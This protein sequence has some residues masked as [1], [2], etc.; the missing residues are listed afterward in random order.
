MN[1]EKKSIVLKISNQG[2]FYN[3]RGLVE[4]RDTNFPEKEDFSLSERA[5][6]FWEVSMLSFD[7]RTGELVIE[8]IDYEKKQAGDLLAKQKPKYSIRRIT[9]TKLKWPALE[10]ILNYYR[11]EAFD[12]IVAYPEQS[13]KRIPGPPL[14]AFDPK[15]IKEKVDIKEKH[16]L[17]KTKF[18]MGFVELDKKIKGLA[19]PIKI[20]LENPHIIPEFDH[21]KPF[22][23][24]A[25]GKRTI[26]ITG[27]VEINN[28][29]EKKVRCRSYEI[30]QINESLITNVK[31][32][33]L[34]DAVFKPKIHTIDK[35]LF[36][37][38][39]YFE[40]TPDNSLGNRPPQKARD[41][42][43]EILEL[44]GIRNRKQLIYLSGKLQSK[45]TGLR[46]TLSPTFGFLFHVEGEEMDHFIWELL[47][48]HATYI[49]SIEKGGLSVEK[50][51]KLLEREINFIR[52]HGR[53]Q[54][55]ENTQS[56]D[57]VFSKVN[58]E[59]SGSD[60]IDG[61]P[62]WRVRV[63]EKLI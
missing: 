62:K 58:H 51:L 20:I 26:Q 31:R 40:P 54:Y 9:F 25:L 59:H 33:R 46:F 13:K 37:P 30:D 49:W 50:K 6:I 23:A 56:S 28:I 36:T 3:D 41:F 14:S 4:W 57:F 21:V 55:L 29:G 44:K 38:E 48:S 12:S 19:E 1:K 11:R 24:K 34:K 35:S 18:K 2:V 63:N 47:N 16:P 60:V 43:K 42:M 45:N 7:K 52:D 10:K 17:M 39:E 32:L 27:Y 22:F 61:F 8:V 15:K 53:R 5:P